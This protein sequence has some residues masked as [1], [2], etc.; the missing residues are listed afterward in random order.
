MDVSIFY[1]SLKTSWYYTGPLN[2]TSRWLKVQN[3]R[4]SSCILELQQLYSCITRAYKRYA[5]HIKFTRCFSDKL[6]SGLSRAISPR[7]AHCSARA[8]KENQSVSTF[9]LG[10]FVFSDGKISRLLRTSGRVQKTRVRF[11]C[12]RQKYTTPTPIHLSL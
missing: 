3:E 1:Q 8:A 11:R 7:P 9:A 2:I 10:V 6:V 12:R 4:S 5:F